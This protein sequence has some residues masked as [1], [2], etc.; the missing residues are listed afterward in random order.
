MR[1]VRFLFTSLLLAAIA[2]SSYAQRKPGYDK[3]AARYIHEWNKVITDIQ[4]YDSF[5]PP[6]ATRNF[7]YN[8]IAAYQAALPGYPE[9]RSLEGQIKDLEG[10]PRPD[11]SLAYDW[12][13]S[14][15]TA[16][17]EITKLL[18]YADSPADSL[19]NVHLQEIA[20]G[21]VPTDVI[22]RSKAYGESVVAA[23]KPWIKGDGF[24]KI[25][26]HNVYVIPQGKGLWE[27]TP[28]D[29]KEP[30]DP[31]WH[32]M[33]R[34]LTLDRAGELACEAPNK[35]STAKKS[36]FYKEALEVY[37]IGRKLTEEQRTIA[38]YWNDNPNTSL[39]RGHAILNVKWMTPPAHWIN[40]S[41][42]ASRLKGQ[43]MMEALETYALVSIS[44]YDGFISC[45]DAKYTYN[46]MR[47]VTYINRTIDSTWEPLI[48]T[49]P[50]PEHTSGHSTIS[51]S[52]AQV[53]THIFGENFA[54][55][56]STAIPIGFAP[57][58]FSS[59]LEAARE[60]GMSRIYGG[61]HYQRGNVAGRNN[62][63]R[64]GERVVQRV[65]TRV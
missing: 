65:R 39:H 19:Y 28:P 21:G 51:A 6:K 23:M 7:V 49:P 61:I 24:V 55:T 8:N 15:I 40:I 13:V 34:P 56:D 17:K 1:S 31:F 52:A 42:E 14:A 62:G 18:L 11:L 41:A 53:L 26:A 45:W 48:Q 30:A 12:R 38:L 25:Q 20:G 60:A 9:C 3:D 63:L 50:F 59:F 10:L 46:V 44:M 32:Q 27:A 16:Y 29:F 37:N 33:M 47:P 22:E 35:Y 58:R 5:S 64:V 2:T 43:G 4:I 36:S 57:R 54:F